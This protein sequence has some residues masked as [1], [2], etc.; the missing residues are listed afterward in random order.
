MTATTFTNL[1]SLLVENNY[2]END[3][4]I[5]K[6]SIGNDVPKFCIDFRIIE[7]FCTEKVVGP[8]FLRWF[9]DN[10]YP[11]DVNYFHGNHVI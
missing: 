10:F 11:N 7:G 9:C 1:V 2:H 3:L 5:M 8:Y 4:S 6:E